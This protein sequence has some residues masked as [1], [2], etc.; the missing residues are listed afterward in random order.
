MNFGIAHRKIMEMTRDEFLSKINE[1]LIAHQFEQNENVYTCIQQMEQ[2]GSTININGQVFQQPGQVIINKFVITD[3]G[4][5]W[6]SDID[7][8]NKTPWEQM[9]FEV[10]QNDQ[11]MQIIEEC[12]YFNEGDRIMNN[13]LPNESSRG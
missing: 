10:F 6:I 7:D 8:T 9:R 12:F 3:L 13:F 4:E 2:P 11:L 5:G 1:I